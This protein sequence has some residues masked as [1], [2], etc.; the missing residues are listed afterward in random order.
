MRRRRVEESHSKTVSY[1]YPDLD[2]AATAIQAAYRGH[3]AR[4]KITALKRQPRQQQQGTHTSRVVGGV[5]GN[6]TGVNTATFPPCPRGTSQQIVAARATAHGNRRGASGFRRQQAHKPPPSSSSS[7]ERYLAQMKSSSHR[8]TSTRARRH[9]YRP[10]AML[11]LP[12]RTAVYGEAAA[13]QLRV[14]ASDS[15]GENVRRFGSDILF[16]MKNSN[17]GCTPTPVGDG[18]FWYEDD[19][20]RAARAKRL[21]SFSRPIFITPRVQNAKCLTK[22]YQRIEGTGRD[23]GRRGGRNNGCQGTCPEPCAARYVHTTEKVP[24]EC[25]KCKAHQTLF[26]GQQTSKE[27]LLSCHDKP[28]VHFHNESD[29]RYYERRMAMRIGDEESCEECSYESH[30]ERDWRRILAASIN[31]PD[32]PGRTER[33]VLAHYQYTPEPLRAESAADPVL[34]FGETVSP[35]KQEPRVPGTRTRQADKNHAKKM[36]QNMK[37]AAGAFVDDSSEDSSPPL[38]RKQLQFMPSTVWPSHRGIMRSYREIIK[39]EQTKRAVNVPINASSR[40]QIDHTSRRKDACY[41]NLGGEYQANEARFDEVVGHGTS[42][43]KGHQTST[44]PEKVCGRKEQ[45]MPTDAFDHR[46]HACGGAHPRNPYQGKML[47]VE[48]TLTKSSS[49][50]TGNREIGFRSGQLLMEG[51]RNQSCEKKWTAKICNGSG[52]QSPTSADHKLAAPLRSRAAVRAQ[53]AKF[54]NAA[55]EQKTQFYSCESRLSKDTSGWRAADAESHYWSPVTSLLP[56]LPQK[57]VRERHEILKSIRSDCFYTDDMAIV[58]TLQNMTSHNLML[59]G[60]ISAHFPTNYLDGSAVTTYHPQ[61]QAWFFFG[62]MPEPRC[63]HTAVL[64]GDAII[65]AG[66]LD[67]LCVTSSG[68]MQPSNKAFLFN[69]RKRSWRKLADM[70]CER[71]YHA[72]VGWSDRMIVFGGMDIARRTLPSAEVYS[73]K[74]DQWTLVHPMPV[75]LMGMAAVTLDNRIWILGGVT[76]DYNGSNLQDSTY[77]FDPRT[78]TWVTHSPMPRKRAFCSAVPLQRDI[79]LV[80]GIVDIRPLECTDRIDVLR[81]AQGSWERCASLPGPMHS[82]RVV[83]TGY[84][85][86]LVG[87]QDE[88][89]NPTEDVIVFDRIQL[90]YV[91]CTKTPKALAGFA[92]VVLPQDCT[93]LKSSPWPGSTATPQERWHAATVIQ[94]AYRQYRNGTLQYYTKNMRYGPSKVVASRQTSMPHWPHTCPRDL[95]PVCIEKWPPSKPST[96]TLNAYCGAGEP[97]E[98]KYAHYTTLRADMDPNL[99]MLLHMG[100]SFLKTKSALGLRVAPAWMSARLRMLEQTQQP[101]DPRF[102]VILVVGGLDPRNPMGSAGGY[103]TFNRKSGEMV[104][105][106]T[107]FVMSTETG[108]WERLPDMW[109]ERACHAS[110]ATEDSVIVFGG[111]GHHGRLLSSVEEYDLKK[112]EWKQLNSMPEPRMGM[113]AVVKEGC[114][115]L[116]GGMSERP[117]GPAVSEVLLYSLQHDSWA[118]GIPLRLPR[119]FSSATLINGKIWLCGGCRTADVEEE[120]PVSMNSIDVGS[121][122]SEWKKTCKL[123]VARHSASTATIGSCIFIMGG[124]NSQEWGVLSKNTLI[125]TDR[126]AILSPNPMPQAVAGHTAV[127]VLPSASQ[128]P[129]SSIK[130][131]SAIFERLT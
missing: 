54:D 41:N 121:K 62:T 91:R 13:N 39:E 97:G 126:N 66:G 78:D 34:I 1:Q 70:H 95:A 31:L 129:I 14:D 118:Q 19:T 82:V 94:R 114:I 48:G 102:P 96:T 17:Q 103:S 83:K 72:A 30:P 29:R 40:H 113:A 9:R 107:T 98:R 33:W 22:N 24:E 36:P 15:D 6:L 117:N 125:V 38:D 23:E 63:Y 37:S 128:H 16:E 56:P 85:V 86:Y 105:T 42:V 52:D 116:L 68:H 69:L 119:A 60:G 11:P 99:G 49:Q 100:S 108:N 4:K 18:N 53:A 122:H 110:I 77:V 8:R 93:V 79:W 27:C 71:A 104:A 5:T 51:R 58:P 50:L 90:S 43:N 111:R 92:A 46:Q 32:D 123:A 64:V 26:G 59:I 106:K 87:G 61:K 35:P 101:C 28:G 7:S 3:L 12:L 44:Y 81:V 55:G 25:E 47:P 130:W 74:Q 84:E 80:G 124:I 75:G 131:S 45:T 115:W 120:H 10:P 20:E 67:P 109:D 127:T 88:M 76:R 65:V 21:A 73:T 89:N 2:A 112:N 57:K